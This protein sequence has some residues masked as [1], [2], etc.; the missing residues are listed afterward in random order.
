MDTYYASRKRQAKGSIRMQFGY[1]PATPNPAL[2]L[3]PF[4]RWT[5]CE[6]PL[7]AGDFYVRRHR[8]HHF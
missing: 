3:A 5:L 7:S 6:K 2:N 1:P 8:K 4:V